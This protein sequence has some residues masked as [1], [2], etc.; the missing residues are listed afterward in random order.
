MLET[1]STP[2]PQCGRKDYVNERFQWRHRESNPWCHRAPSKPTRMRVKKEK[3]YSRKRILR[4][5]QSKK[6]WGAAEMRNTG[7][8]FRVPRERCWYTKSETIAGHF[9]GGDLVTCER[10]TM[11]QG[12]SCINRNLW[13]F[14]K[15]Q[16]I[17]RYCWGPDMGETG[18]HV[19]WLCHISPTFRNCGHNTGLFISPSG[20]SELDCATTKTDTAERSISIGREYLQVFFLY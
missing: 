19:K 20:I 14:V 5:V 18:D 4:S 9:P 17:E 12:L 15:L 11:K 3:S 1:E 6:I 2:E 10:T 16:L 7:T 8:I 13:S